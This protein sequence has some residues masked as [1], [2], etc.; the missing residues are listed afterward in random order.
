[1]VEHGCVLLQLLA[2]LGGQRHLVDVTTSALGFG[3]K[4]TWDE[5]TTMDHILH[6]SLFVVVVVVLWIT[7]HWWPI[8]HEKGVKIARAYLLHQHQ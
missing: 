5:A 8:A 6:A 1:M 4:A 7:G 3:P 2:K